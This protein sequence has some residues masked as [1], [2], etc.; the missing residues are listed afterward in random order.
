MKRKL[1]LELNIEF[2]SEAQQDIFADMILQ[3][4]FVIKQSMQ[5]RHKKNVFSFKQL[6][7]D[8]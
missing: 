2:W 5:E 4:M 3:M 1:N 7:E 8:E 6:E